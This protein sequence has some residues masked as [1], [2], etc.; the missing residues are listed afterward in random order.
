M[1][2]IDRLLGDSTGVGAANVDSHH[3]RHGGLPRFRTARAGPE[4]GVPATVQPVTI[5]HV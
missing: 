3:V 2:I 1:F 4:A 5:C